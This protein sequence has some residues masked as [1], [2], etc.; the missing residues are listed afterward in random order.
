MSTVFGQQTPVIATGDDFT[1][2]VNASG[3]LYVYGA[4]NP[5]GPQLVEPSGVWTS[6]A[7][8]PTAYADAHVLAIQ[9]DGTLWAWGKNTRGQLGDDTIIDRVTPVQVG[10]FNVVEVACG[11]EFSIARLSSGAV[12]VWG[13]NTYGQIGL[14]ILD[15]TLVSGGTASTQIEAGVEGSPLNIYESPQAFDASNSYISIAASIINGVGIRTDG[16]MHSWGYGPTYQ[17]GL[18]GSNYFPHTTPQRIGTSNAWTKVFSGEDMHFALQGGALYVWGGGAGS[19]DGLGSGVPVPKQPTRVGSD[20]DWATVAVGRTH[21]LGLKSDGSLYGWGLNTEGQLGFAVTGS[22]TGV[23]WTPFELP[24]QIGQTILAVGAGDMFSTIISSPDILKTTGVNDVGQLG[25]GYQTN[26]SNYDFEDDFVDLGLLYKADLVVS[27]ITAIELPSR[28][29]VDPITN[30][31]AGGEFIV[32]I[33]L[34]N[35][36]EIDIDTDFELEAYL[37]PSAY[38]ADPAAVALNFIDGATV[39]VDIDAGAN[40]TV[41]ARLTLPTTIPHGTYNLIIVGD[42]GTPVLTEITRINNTSSLDG[43]EFVPDVALSIEVLDPAFTLGETVEVRLTIENVGTWTASADF[44]LAAVLGTTPYFD[45]LDAQVLAV[46]TG[47]VSVTEDLDPGESIDVDLSLLIP[48]GFP[49]DE[50]YMIARADDARVIDEIV[51][52]NNDAVADDLFQVGVDITLPSI[53]ISDPTPTLGAD[54]GATIFID[55]LGSRELTEDFVLR[56]ILSTAEDEDLGDEAAIQAAFNDPSVIPLPFAGGSLD[57]TVTDDIASQGSISLPVI[58]EFPAEL[59]LGKYRLILCVDPDN[60]VVE[61]NETNNCI[62]ADEVFEFLPD[63]VFD[64]DEGVV[65][66]T[67]GVYAAGDPMEITIN[68]EN[69]GEGRVPEGAEFDIRIFLSPTTGMNDP[70]EVDLFEAYTHTVG[71]GGFAPTDLLQIV[72]NTNLP[73][74]LTSGDYYIAAIVDIDDSVNEQ[75]ELLDETNAV[76]REDGEANNVYY[77]DYDPLL[78]VYSTVLSFVGIGLAEAVD[79]PA[80]IFETDG[81]GVWFGQLAVFNNDNDAAQSP[82]IS[83]GESALF[84]TSFAGPVVIEFDW[85]SITSSAQNKLAFSMIGGGTGIQNTISGDSGGWQTV[86]RLVPDGAQAQWEY[87][88][89]FDDFDDVVY[90]DNIIVTDVT[91]PDLIIDGIQLT[92]DADVIESGSYVLLRDQLELTVNLRNQGTDTGLENAVLT[93]YLSTDRTLNRHDGDPGTV[94]DIIVRQEELVGPFPGGSPAFSGLVIDLPADLP[95]GDYYVIAYIDDYLDENG[96]FLP[97]TTDSNGQIAEFT[98]ATFFG[99]NNNSFVTADPVVSVIGLPDFTVSGLN[100]DPEYYR[101]VKPDASANSFDLDFTLSNQGLVSFIGDLNSTVVFSKDPIIDTGDY[102]L[103]NYTYSG[104]L[105]AVG[106]APSNEELVTPDKIDFNP[107]LIEEGYIGERLFLG[108]IVDPSNSLEELDETNNDT[109]LLQ[110]D[111]ILSELELVE[112]LDLAPATIATQNVVIVNDEVA[113]Y[114]SQ[115]VPWVGQT[116]QTFDGVDGVTSVIVGNNEI[117]SFSVEMTNNSNGALVS[118]HWRVSSQNDL[119]GRD[120]LSFTVDGVEVV[121]SIAGTLD[122]WQEISV[123]VPSG[124]HTL[125]WRYIKDGAFS[126]GADRG[127]VD[128]LRITDLPNL[129]VTGVTTDPN[130]VYSPGDSIGTWSV[131]VENTGIAIAPGTPIDLVVRLLPS[132]NFAADAGVD[133]ITITDSA[134]FTAGEVRTYDNVTYGSLLIPDTAVYSQEFYYLGANVDDT[135]VVI[136]STEADNANYTSDADI[137]LG[138]PDIVIGA[139]GITTASSGHDYNEAAPQILQ[140][141]GLSNSGEGTLL[142]G[143][144]FDI[145]LYASQTNDPALI[146]SSSSHVL[147]TQTVDVL[148]DVVSGGALPPIVVNVA[149]PYGIAVG[150]YY[151]GLSIDSSGDVV[152][153]GP[154]PSPFRPFDVRDDGEGNNIYFTPSTEF[155]VVGVTLQEA[156]EDVVAPLNAFTTSGDGTWFGRLNA[157]D[158]S[159]DDDNQTFIDG[160]GAQSPSLNVGEN[161]VLS[162]IIDSTSI[163][164]FDWGLD[165]ISGDNVLSLRLN[166]V[167]IRS[168]SG[169]TPITTIDPAVLVPDNSVLEWVYTKGADTTGDAAFVDNV[170]IA[171]NTLPD[172]VLTN[173]DYTPGTYVLDVAGI[174][175][176]PEQKL[177]TFTLDVTVEAENQGEDLPVNVGAFTEADLEVRLSTDQV[178]GNADDIV[179]GSFTQVEGALLESGDLI[180]FIGGI[181]LGDNIPEGDYYLIS[182]IDSNDRVAEFSD[183]NN[184]FITENRDVTI[185]ARPRLFAYDTDV[186]GLTSTESAFYTDV[187]DYDEGILYTPGGTMSVDLSIANIGLDDLIDDDTGVLQSFVNEVYIVAV[188]RAELAGLVLPAS[189]SDFEEIVGDSLIIDD[190]SV[191]ADLKGRRDGFP[192]GDNVDIALELTL[193]NFARLSSLFA[194]DKGVTDYVY[195][196]RL[197]I[198]APNDILESGIKNVWNNV[199]INDLV[200]SAADPIVDPYTD[201]DDGLFSISFGVSS[202]G[203]FEALY[204]V[205]A[206]PTGTPAEQANFLAYAF[207]RNPAAGDTAGNQF[208][209]SYGFDAVDGDNYLSITFDFQYGVT[210]LVYTVEATSDLITWDEVAVINTTATASGFIEGAGSESLLG[211]GGLIDSDDNIISITDF[212]S[213]ARI[214][215]ID[216]VSTDDPSGSRF[217]RVNVSDAVTIETP[218]GP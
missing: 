194:D 4:N 149:L 66:T 7:V 3:D 60:T 107:N 151:V 87:I 69:A 43:L 211:D 74:G 95:P 111:F 58:F 110:N 200:A 91:D 44:E 50:Y 51:L 63:I 77:A 81:D 178:Y 68:L 25:L 37:S 143:S 164:T 206:D 169:D 218:P 36:G 112:G 53:I 14:E 121:P 128:N 168:I 83:G 202:V 141:V 26:G 131:T 41:G 93:V 215:L 1:A 57:L 158:L 205:T 197:V 212:G 11:E 171:P 184:I 210:D 84:R 106:G 6:V 119:L 188:D 208:P 96:A 10:L 172:L 94:E 86:T 157:G 179:L 54:L 31:V 5:A 166:G 209:G 136:E 175:G 100:S 42:A 16:S 20:S 186:A 18:S 137:Q 167:E 65:L 24:D 155:D 156:L 2:I 52:L 97:G 122:G 117:S 170:E 176:A 217:I 27:N 203:D 196:L 120:F 19:Q 62:L 125:T 80:N 159:T 148:A 199:D 115:M 70:G 56:A 163:V 123:V 85:R 139:L 165:G 144:S 46:T 204:G 160:D 35:I 21:T 195:F 67:P 162:L 102:A 9:S 126:I 174:I 105:T 216:N 133:L 34:E 127:W 135:L 153:Q 78:D 73:L 190:F 40:T 103:L 76:V 124:S 182:K 104:G 130:T 23:K 8:S 187:M 142:A 114:D 47:D 213:Y 32:S 193:P 161:A 108:V 88:E 132:K 109:Y 150:D 98:T 30:L 92:D 64:D 59:D 185:E 201:T 13:D 183:T 22:Q 38:I 134:G 39:V 145:T 191:L 48:F 138:R 61:F 180:R 116:T 17:L 99:E 101:I 146:A 28:P 90:V 140:I 181:H 147:T 45:G 33:D 198:D 177:G 118:F 89:G 49:D 82:A 15:K 207:N 189:T 79:L 55:N 129:A 29:G 192:D 75:T 214:T 71:V 152:E 12:Y 154:L 173:I 113:P 72:L